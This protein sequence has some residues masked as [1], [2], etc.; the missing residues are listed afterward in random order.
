MA[1]ILSQVLRRFVLS[2]HVATS[3]AWLGAV[4]AFLALSIAGQRSRDVS[5]VGGIYWS[6][7]LIGGWVIVPS[8]LLALLTG[9]WIALG[10]PWGL[11]RY[12]WV[13]VKFGLTIVATLLLLL[14]QFTAVARAAREAAEFGTSAIPAEWPLAQRLVMD[15]SLAVILLLGTT[16]LSV[17]K[18][19]GKTQR[20]IRAELR[21]QES[22]SAAG[23]VISKTVLAYAAI[24]L[25]VLAILVMHLVGG[26]IARH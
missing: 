15:A 20:G 10:T 26:G 19:W 11:V 13:L 21:E 4:A 12:Y 5:V 23:L 9:I 16:A 14:H 3:V 1:M 22:E 2:A 6:M 18:P 8:S 17:Y 7:N 25:T 24:G